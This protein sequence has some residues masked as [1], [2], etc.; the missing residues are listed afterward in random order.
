MDRI[1]SC[2]LC[3]E[4]VDA[5]GTDNRDMFLVHCVCAGRYRMVV[6]DEVASRSI[7]REDAALASK[8][9]RAR[10][11]RGE[12]APTFDFGL[13]PGPIPG[14]FTMAELRVWDAL[15]QRRPS[16]GDQGKRVW[17]WQ[18][19]GNHPSQIRTG[20]LAGWDGEDLKLEG[21]HLLPWSTTTDWGFGDPPETN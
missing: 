9:A 13:S 15:R 18:L 7:P 10:Y 20:I 17:A 3:G 11:E 5:V 19:P 6:E 12:E 1:D 2:P 14:A 16:E 21:G 4:P 8:F